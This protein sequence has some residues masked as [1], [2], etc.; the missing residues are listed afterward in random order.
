MPFYL[1]ANDEN[2]YDYHNFA[3]FFIRVKHLTVAK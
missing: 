3:H 1:K 2:S